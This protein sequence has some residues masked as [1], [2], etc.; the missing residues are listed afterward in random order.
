MVG[1][2]KIF[3]AFIGV[4]LLALAL[5][6]PPAGAVTLDEEL[7][8]R[9]TFSAADDI[10]LLLKKGANPNALSAN[11]LPMVSV[12]ASRRDSGALSV[13]KALVAAGADVNRGGGS[14]QYPLIIAAREN[15]LEMM[16]YLIGLE[17]IDL[18]VRDPNGLNPLE[19]AEYYGNDE[20][21]KLIR[22][23][24]EG[25]AAQEAERTSPHRRDDM[26]AQLAF[27]YCEHQYMYYYYT[28]RQDNHSQEFVE[29]EIDRLRDAITKQI[30]ELHQTFGASYELALLMK[31]EVSPVVKTELDAMISNRERKRRGIGTE[32]DLKDRCGRIATEWFTQYIE[33]GA[34]YSGN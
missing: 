24:Y 20:V 4:V 14:N 31:S 3:R 11:G 1:M 6:S 13:L 12:A 29:S 2:F 10:Q 32:Q 27:S 18:G 30:D 28:S 26:I 5:P 23:V 8:Y 19:I 9:V 7:A 15:N 17:G 34:P 25:R 21:Q 16:R 22:S 33:S